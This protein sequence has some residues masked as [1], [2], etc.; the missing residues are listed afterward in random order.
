M[1]D[2]SRQTELN[3]AIELLF[4]GYREFTAHPDEVLL[5]RGLARVHHRVL[6]FVGR[7]P[8]ISVNRLFAILGVSKQ[9]LHAP[10]K[11]LLDLGLVESCISTQDRRQRQLSLTAEGALLEQELSGS[12]REQLAGVFAQLGPEQEAAWREVMRGIGAR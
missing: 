6:Y 2:P 8:G 12:Q 10:L 3:E 7:N 1:V 11:R 5:E 4:F 9:A